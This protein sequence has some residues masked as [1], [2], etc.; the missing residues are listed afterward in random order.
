MANVKLENQVVDVL[1]LCPFC[2]Q[3]IGPR[4]EEWFLHL[5]KTSFQTLPELLR[6]IWTCTTSHPRESNNSG[7][8]VSKKTR[9][10]VTI[11][12]ICD[13]HRYETLILPLADQYIWPTVPE[14]D[15]LLRRLKE[16]VIIEAVVDVYIDLSKTVL[17]HTSKVSWKE[18]RVMKE[19]VD[20][21]TEVREI[22]DVCG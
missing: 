8:R 19:V 15:T 21:V 7:R 6:R 14:Y 4:R 1:Y 11:D 3:P 18:T 13:Q 22:T 5:P 20:Q 16:E 10:T 12:Q 2:D 9:T 17:F